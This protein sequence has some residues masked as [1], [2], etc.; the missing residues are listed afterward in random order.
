M[1]DIKVLIVDIDRDR[2]W[3]N[4]RSFLV[5]SA[6]S[7]LFDGEKRFRV[8]DSEEVDFPDNFTLVLLHD[9][10]KNQ[11]L[12]LER[13][14]DK[15]IRYTGGNPHTESE[16]FWI[17]RRSITSDQ[18]ISESEAKEILN[19]VESGSPQDKLPEI[20]KPLLRLRGD[21]KPIIYV[22]DD[23]NNYIV[24]QEGIYTPNPAL[25][26]NEISEY[27]REEKSVSQYL[28]Y[29]KEEILGGFCEMLNNLS[30]TF[31]VKAP[32]LWIPKTKAGHDLVAAA[33]PPL[34]TS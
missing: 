31:T 22:F 34:V 27:Y 33:L 29:F 3:K 24:C 1:S 10:D 18:P 21:I 4:A 15:I 20:M 26:D 16:D 17:A 23:Y 2:C 9:N 8:T 19:W 25:I 7:Y 11:W 30:L 14:T 12:Q 5:K 32:P 13:K 6:D 28:E